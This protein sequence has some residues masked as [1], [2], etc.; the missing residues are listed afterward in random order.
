M[1]WQPLS[2]FPAPANKLAWDGKTF[3]LTYSPPAYNGCTVQINV[4]TEMFVWNMVSHQDDPEYQPLPTHW[5]YVGE[6]PE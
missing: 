3:V 2:A 5:K 4:A 1:S 6:L